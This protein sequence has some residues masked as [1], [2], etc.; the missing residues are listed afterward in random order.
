MFLTANSASTIVWK[1]VNRGQ[2][3]LLLYKCILMMNLF[4]INLIFNLFHV[5]VV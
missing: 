1:T 2:I 5:S 4:S 3:Y